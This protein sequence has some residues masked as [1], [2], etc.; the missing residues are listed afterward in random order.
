LYAIIKLSVAFQ[1]TLRDMILLNH[2]KI[3]RSIVLKI[4]IYL[5]IVAIAVSSYM[6][7]G[8]PYLKEL[9]IE[10]Q[11][12]TRINDLNFLN[13]ILKVTLPAPS[14][15]VYISLPSN[16]P[17]CAN[18]DLPSLPAGWSYHCSNQ[19]NYQKTNGKGWIPVDF[20]ELSG[21]SFLKILPADPV[22]SADGLFY[23]AYAAGQ[24]GWVLTSLLNSDKFL[25][26]SA[27]S[28]GGTDLNRFE[29]GSDLNIWAKASGLAG[30]RKF[31]KSFNGV[32]DYENIGLSGLDS[33]GAEITIEFWAKPD[34]AKTTSVII[35]NPDDS[36]N[37]INIHFPWVGNMIMWDYGDIDAGGRL[38][39]EFK[40][41]WYDET[42]HWVFISGIDGMKIYRNGE[43]IAEN[44]THSVF[45]KGDKTLDIGRGL[46]LFW[47]GFLGEIRIYNRVL[48]AKEIQLLYLLK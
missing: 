29:I 14:N 11:D 16:D 34:E 41:P 36:A 33:P 8:K 9:A 7:Y 40:L 37:R 31:N 10:G 47:K 4:L 21:S 12:R 46:P 42:A 13:S 25:K 39:T 3:N 38:T 27:G 18:L 44:K 48:S 23:Y 5:G 22:N 45:T 30:H 19:N 2:M 20:T 26:Q 43:I 24:E 1:S 28:D 6:Q 32:D 17:S 15:A 35:A